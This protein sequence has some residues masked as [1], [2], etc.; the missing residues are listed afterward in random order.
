VKPKNKDNE[1]GSFCKSKYFIT[2]IGS[3]GVPLTGILILMITFMNPTIVANGDAI[4]D[5]SI[6]IST[7]NANTENLTTS[8]DKLDATVSKLDDRIDKLTLILCDIS[9]G[10]HC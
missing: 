10:E 4:Q 1:W 9:S 5:N 8:I 7:M 2:T 3:V 6:A